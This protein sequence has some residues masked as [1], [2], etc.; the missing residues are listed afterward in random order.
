M[1]YRFNN[2]ILLAAEDQE[3]A[4]LAFPG[5][6][7]ALDNRALRDAFTPHNV[8]A[9][10]S[11]TRSRRWGALAVLLATASLA[12]AAGETLYHDQPKSVVRAIAMVGAVA[13]IVSVIIGVFGVMYR[14][15]KIRWLCDRMATE[16]LRQ[17][18]FQHY[19]AHAASII[20]GADD[21]DARRAYLSKREADFIAYRD[22][23]LPRLDHHLEEI[24]EDEDPGDGALFRTPERVRADSPRLAEYF[25][26]YSTLRFDRQI[27]YCNL[28]L[29]RSGGMFW[30][31]APVKQA[32]LLG[33]MAMACVFA[34]LILH[35]L[36]FVGAIGEIAWMKAPIIHVAA[37]WAAIVALAARTL[38]EGLQPETEAERMRQYRLSLNRIYAQ[39][40]KAEDPNEKIARMMDLEKLAFE[41]MVIFLK[42]NY[43]ARFVM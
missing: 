39:F 21:E 4:R 29:R 3:Q 24:V 7:F 37:I 19:A 16:R 23:W 15:R 40:E 1:A 38:E 5:V 32:K 18:H 26:A 25:R 31:Y 11:K 41:E 30:K 42:T 2:D 9:N 36:V 17:F 12:I 43:E 20:A 13:G 35:G 6:A 33:V 10:M 8:R 27:G 22:G 28:I 14:K 34:I